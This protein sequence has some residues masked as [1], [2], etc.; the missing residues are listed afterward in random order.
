MSK[1][2]FFENIVKLAND[3]NYIENIM[4]EG[5]KRDREKPENFSNWYN[6]ITSFG[7][8]KHS[9]IIANQIF[10]YEEVKAM[11]ETENIEEVNW[12]KIEKIL[13]PTISKMK[14][15]KIYNIKNGCFSNKFDFKTCMTTRENLAKHLWQLNDMSCFYETGGHTELVVREFIPYVY[16]KMPTIYDGMPLREEVRVFYNIDTKKIEYIVDYWNYDYCSPYIENRTDKIIFDWFHNK[17][18]NREINHKE[19]LKELFK[20]IEKDI[21]GLKFNNKIN[22]IWSI[23]FLWEE[24]TDEIYL[25]DMAR[26]EKSAYWDT[27]KIKE[28][29]EK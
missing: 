9:N 15:H 12:D 5:Y 6:T 24:E 28:R 8:F 11:Q 18:G 7:N 14:K 19:K 22:G 23:D 1:D 17:I 16:E 10:S 4:K 25:I 27:R 26:G 29:E 20:R 13:E 2:N 3:K 21:N